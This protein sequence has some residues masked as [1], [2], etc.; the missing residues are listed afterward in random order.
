[1]AVSATEVFAKAQEKARLGQAKTQDIL[2]SLR[3]KEGQARRGLEGSQGAI[4]RELT[5]SLD[6]LRRET[7]TGGTG[8]GVQQGAP[9]QRVDLQPPVKTGGTGGAI[10]SAIAKEIAGI[11]EGNQTTFTSDPNIHG[12]ITETTTREQ[13]RNFG[14]GNAQAIASIVSLLPGMRKVA[15]QQLESKRTF[16][17]PELATAREA[18]ATNLARTLVD[19]ENGKATGEDITMSMRNIASTHLARSPEVFKAAQ[20]E[21]KEIQFTN[22]EAIQANALALSTAAL[23]DDELFDPDTKLSILNLAVAMETGTNEDVID[24]VGARQL[25]A[26]DSHSK[27]IRVQELRSN[28][29]GIASTLQSTATSRANQLSTEQSTQFQ[30]ADR[31][32]SGQLNRSNLEQIRSR[33]DLN[34]A[35]LSLAKRTEQDKVDL[36]K[37]QVINAQLESGMRRLNIER[38]QFAHGVDQV[39]I[40]TRMADEMTRAERQRAGL[41][42]DELGNEVVKE[43]FENTKQNRELFKNINLAKLAGIEVGTRE[44]EQRIA[45]NTATEDTRV[46]LLNTRLGADKFNLQQ[47]RRLADALAGLSDV[48]LETAL[49]NLDRAKIAVV[50]EALDSTERSGTAAL[51][52]RVLELSVES[53]E[54]GITERQAQLSRF[55]SDEGI[56]RAMKDARLTS[57]QVGNQLHIFQADVQPELHATIIR[58]R[59]LRSD[60]TAK[61]IEKF[62]ADADANNAAARSRVQLI[63]SEGFRTELGISNG[64]FL[65]PNEELTQWKSLTENGSLSN[66]GNRGAVEKL[67][68]LMFARGGEVLLIND[69]FGWGQGNDTRSISSRELVKAFAV[70]GNEHVGATA[71]EQR[72]AAELVRSVGIGAIPPEKGEHIWAYGTPTADNENG[73]LIS[74]AIKAALGQEAFANKTN[75]MHDIWS[76]QGKRTGSRGRRAV[77][78]GQPE[79]AREEVGPVKGALRKVGS[80]GA[81]AAMSG[82]A[83]ALQAVKG[84]LA[85]T[86]GGLA[87]RA[88]KELAVGAV[89]GE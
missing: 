80:V 14:G 38:G 51:R 30:A 82:I 40:G 20:R 32:I 48:Q 84:T 13:A 56:D 83:Q 42:A 29:V 18:D 53:G 47:T 19:A 9:A 10:V 89:Q 27:K 17:D 39:M 16:D 50:R 57:L 11:D 7:A 77:S 28:Q 62:S 46:Q 43:G 74:L 35:S 23:N 88:G 81:K 67:Q 61:Q 78:K 60:L 41:I 25:A 45:F 49:V 44:A 58:E 15:V 69:S 87:L 76:F 66:S 63:E 8:G 71:A 85:N 34:R 73:H 4:S 2:E 1:M 55:K 79:V 5:R 21:K 6:E 12:K 37:A 70:L 52:K 75:V 86:P 65:T 59:E 33:T 3:L 68:S 24:A 54:L 26:N 72:K 22:N 64:P 36:G 31:R